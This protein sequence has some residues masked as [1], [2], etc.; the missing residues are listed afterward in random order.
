MSTP[1]LQ[2][3]DSLTI[4][5][6]LIHSS[7][8]VFPIVGPQDG[9]LSYDLLQ[10]AL[11]SGS[12][13]VCEQG[14]ASVNSLLAINR[15]EHPVL[16]LDGEELVGGKQNRM[17][18]SSVL[19]PKGRTLLPVSCVE[20]GRWHDVAPS[21]TT[22]E[23]CYPSLRREKTE[24]VQSS[25]SMAD[26]HRTDQIRVWENIRERQQGENV[27][28]ETGAMADIYAEKRQ[29]LELFERALPYQDRAVGMAVAIGGR[30][31]SADLFD[32]AA[33][34]RKLWRKLVRASAMDAVSVPSGKPVVRAR[35]ERMLQ[36]VRDAN[37]ETFPSPGLGEDMRVGGGGVV[38]SALVYEGAVVHAALFRTHNRIRGGGRMASQSVRRSLRET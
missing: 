16:I 13:E 14:S 28:S 20:Q 15:G 31:V 26:V 7:L 5:E 8:T 11:E 35:A 21:F 37:I 3:V 1:L 29:S 23:A 6:P 22:R 27:R 17:V 34:M 4:G 30:M 19:L 10:D 2:R 38:G 33:T 25:L 9:E 24:Q 12:L 36:R 18:N 32:S